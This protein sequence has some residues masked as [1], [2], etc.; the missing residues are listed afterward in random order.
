MNSQAGEVSM[1]GWER[2]SLKDAIAVDAMLNLEL[3][4]VKTC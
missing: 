3:G 2:N 1:L 4:I